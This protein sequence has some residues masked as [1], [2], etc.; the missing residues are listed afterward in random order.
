MK[1]WTRLISFF[2]AAVMLLAMPA[3]AAEEAMPMASRYIMSTCVYLD[4]TATT[5]FRVW[6][7]VIALGIMDEVG[8]YK[9]KVQESI[10][11]QSWA[12]VKTYVPSE[13]PSMV[14]ED[15]IAHAGY[16]V[17]TGAVTGRYYRAYIT[18]YAKN[19]S[20]EGHVFVYTDPIQL[21]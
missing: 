9:I 3:F 13:Y 12:T 19:S 11:G 8:A 10:D 21:Q 16:V 17:Y 7:E 15:D 6:Y 1:R 5:L 20:G 4:Q 18:L 2:M 14:I